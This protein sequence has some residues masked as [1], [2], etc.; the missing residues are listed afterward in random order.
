MG[1]FALLKKKS[2]KESFVICEIC[3]RKEKMPT[4]DIIDE[5]Y[6]CPVCKQF[7]ILQKSDATILEIDRRGSR[8]ERT[9]TVLFYDDVIGYFCIRQDSSAYSGLGLWY[10]ILPKDISNPKIENYVDN[11]EDF[12]CI[13]NVWFSE[14]FEKDMYGKERLEITSLTKDIK[15]MME[16]KDY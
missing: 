16:K 5:R 14:A 7:E 3:N 1:L 13:P 2:K 15:D 4:K 6:L 10:Y 9:L 12:S 11:Y 8:G